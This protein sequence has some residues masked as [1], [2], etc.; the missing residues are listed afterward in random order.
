MHLTIPHW[1]QSWNESDYKILQQMH[2]QY[3]AWCI[4]CEDSEF[5]RGYLIHRC[6]DLKNLKITLVKQQFETKGFY[7][8]TPFVKLFHKSSSLSRAEFANSVKM[9]DFILTLFLQHR[10]SDYVCWIVALAFCRHK[11]ITQV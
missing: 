7:T 9:I 3:D 10:A 6:L 2:A 5:S 11:I 4:I 8:I 1:W